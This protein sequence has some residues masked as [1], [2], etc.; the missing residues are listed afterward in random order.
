MKSGLIK[1]F[2]TVLL[3]G[4]VCLN[5]LACSENG[6][7]NPG[8][9]SSLP[10]PSDSPSN[11]VDVSDGEETF[12]GTHIYDYEE[13]NDYLISEGESE[14]K[15]VIPKGSDS[16]LQFAAN[17][18][19]MFLELSTG[20][21]LAVVSDEDV[22]YTAGDKYISLG[23]TTVAAAAEAALDTDVGVSGFQIKTKDNSVF[24]LGG[25]R[26]G[27]LYSVY[28]FLFR[29]INFRA[30]NSDAY[31]YDTLAQ[32]KMYDFDITDIPDFTYR[33][34][35]YGAERNDAALTRRLRMNA[36]E[37]IWIKVGSNYWHNTFDYLPKNEYL[38]AHPHWYSTDPSTSQLCFNAQGYG[39]V[40]SGE[41]GD[42]VDALFEKF[43]ECVEANPDVEN[44]T[45]TQQDGS[46]WCTCA[47]CKKELETYGTNAASVVRFCNAISDKWA[48]Y[49]AEKGTDRQINIAFFAYG[50]TEKAPVTKN[51]DGTYSPIDET[52]ICRDNV[53]V[54]YAPIAADY[55][56]SFYESENQGY[57]DTMKAWKACSDK[58]YLWLYSTNFN[59]YMY[60]YNSFN[61]MQNNY[62]FALAQGGSY[63]YDQAQWN[64]AASTGWSV[65]KMWLNSKLQWN[66]SLD[67]NALLDEFFSAYYG[68]AAE[69]MRELF[70]MYRAHCAYL[71]NEVGVSGNIYASLITERNWQSGVLNAMNA[72]I[73]KAYAA[74]DATADDYE[75][76]YDRICLESI[77]YRY[78]D[79]TLYGS[80]KN[81]EEQ[82]QDK[83]E[84]KEDCERVNITMLTEKSNISSLWTDWKI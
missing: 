18:I 71:E 27:T 35:N 33:V 39:T 54:F 59:Y 5:V 6:N 83:R 26:Y 41:L 74:L 49:Q 14:Y 51:T 82:M 65:L 22:S 48:D 52:V 75:T 77:A 24:L 28:E 9:D 29:T 4:C 31:L 67:F 32:V 72:Q 66:S 78:M 70:E 46:G 17:E 63:I 10:Y 38:E 7:R 16:L 60:P 36:E 42:M 23:D 44:I 15:I 40:T 68:P 84:F 11:T 34:N 37:D 13:R 61:S 3:A 50:K 19:V 47:A 21:T 81:Q 45:I 53:N 58:L 8:G 2:I 76:Y 80:R 25:G 20:V 57:A 79:I 30:Y 62:K 12:Q 69:E 73:E 56:H 1:K 43:V 55:N 64:N